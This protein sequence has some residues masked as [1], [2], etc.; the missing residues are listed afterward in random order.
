MTVKYRS[1]LYHLKD[2]EALF[3]FFEKHAGYVS[4]GVY[5]CA[6]IYANDTADLF[7]KLRQEWIKNIKN[8]KR[9]EAKKFLKN[10][11]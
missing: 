3:D 5:Y 9:H 8:R 2:E 1:K 11:Q 4:D 10:G 7:E 6:G